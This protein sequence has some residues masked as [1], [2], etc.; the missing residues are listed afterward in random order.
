MSD[1]VV[2]GA[3]STGGTSESY[4]DYVAF[5]TAGAF[6]PAELQVVTAVTRVGKLAT[7]WATVK[8]GG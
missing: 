8:V 4:W 7:T 3:G 1:G 2:I 5:T 6:S